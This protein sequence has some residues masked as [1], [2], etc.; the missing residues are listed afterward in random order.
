MVV[1]KK[2]LA[3]LVNIRETLRI[4]HGLKYPNLGKVFRREYLLSL[5]RR[6][7]PQAYYSG[8]LPCPIVIEAFKEIR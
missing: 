8:R 3:M 6:L 5:R 2:E 7:G 4:A 1:L